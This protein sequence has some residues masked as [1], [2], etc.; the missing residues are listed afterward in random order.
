[1]QFVHVKSSGHET[2][3]V[4]SKILVEKGKNVEKFIAKTISYS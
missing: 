4:M 1:M 3:G 2:N